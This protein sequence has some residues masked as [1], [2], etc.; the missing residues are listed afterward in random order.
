MDIK[1]YLGK[2]VNIIVD[3]PVG[4]FHP[5][6]KFIYEINYGYVPHTKMSDGEGLDAYLLGITDAVEEFSGRCIAIIHRINDN[7]DKLIVVPEGVSFSN[8]EIDQL[9]DFQEKWFKHII[10]RK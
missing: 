1:K 3:R 8:K 7:D 10:I 6:Y 4:S 5:K 2:V 9:I